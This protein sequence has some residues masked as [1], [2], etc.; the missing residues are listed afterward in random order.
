LPRTLAARAFWLI[1]LL[2]AASLLAS[3][4]IFRISEQRP[5]AHQLAQMVVS[6]VNL[7]RAAV[8]SAEPALRADLLAELAD[9]EGIRVRLAEAGERIAP[10]TFDGPVARLM[11]AEVRR[12][13]GAGT[14]FADARNGEEGFWVS[15]MIGDDEFWLMLPKE[16]VEHPRPWQWLGWS[17]LILALALAGAGLIARQ[18]ARPLRALT[19]AAQDVGQGR[20]PATVPENG[21][22]EIT[23]VA[24]AFNQ[25]AA[26]LA[27]HERE[28]ALVLAGISHDLRTPLARLRLEAEFL[29]EK[30]RAA[31]VAD[32][33]QMDAI[34]AQFLDYARLDGDEARVPTDLAALARETA[35]AFSGRATALHLQIAPL[36]PVLARPLLLRRALA[37]LLDNAVKYAGGDLTLRLEATNGNV[38]LTVTDHGP[39]IPEAQREAAKRPFI[40]LDNARGNAS[41]AGLGLAIVERAARLHGG[42]LRLDN[43][44]HG[45]LAATLE[46]PLAA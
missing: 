24:R 23:A 29:D 38:L 9:S 12:K 5:R 46:L 21:A 32:I 41:G 37:N 35:A 22:R 19:L 8:L 45:G 4:A 39:G 18:V 25:M 33:G 10:L 28:R 17:G 27:D 44:P 14:R 16:R 31:I 36:P 40:R 34:I 13:L 43:L 7:T 15:F 30:T 1:T 26:D 2:I 6:S 20:T 42:R 11:T 3:V